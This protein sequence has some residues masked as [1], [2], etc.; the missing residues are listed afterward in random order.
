MTNLMPGD[1]AVNIS[2]KDIVNNVQYDL[3][4]AQGKV[5]ILAFVKCYCPNCSAEL[6]IL[7]DIWKK[8]Q[9]SGIQIVA[10]INRGCVAW[11][12]P[13]ETYDPA[14]DPIPPKCIQ[15]S[16]EADEKAWLQGTGP[17]DVGGVTFPVIRDPS[18]TNLYKYVT[19]FQVYP[20]L[21][22]IDR[23]YVISYFHTYTPGSVAVEAQDVTEGHILDAANIRTPV[24]IDMVMDISGTM[25][26]VPSGGMTKLALMQQATQMIID[27]L[28]GGNNAQADDR[29]GL[30]WFSDDFDEYRD[31]S[32]NKIVN[33]KAQASLMKQQ[34]AGLNIIN[35]TAM[36]AGLQTAFDTLSANSASGHKRHVFLLTDGIQNIDP[37]VK[38][39]NTHLQIVDGGSWCG[40]HSSV[41]AHPG[42][43]ISSYDTR[44][45]TIG[46]G[47]AGNYGNLLQ[48]IADETGGFYLATNDPAHDMDLL[49]FIHLCNSLA[50][51]SPAIVHH[52]T[53]TFYPKKCEVVEEFFINHSVRKITAVLSWDAVQAGNGSLVF[54]LRAP[55]GTILDLHREM[56]LYESYAI[57]TVYVPKKQN[58]KTISHV[59]NWQMI[60]HGESACPSAYHVLILADDPNTH[61]VVEFPKKSYEVGDIV[62]L[63]IR[64]KVAEQYLV[65]PV[66]LLLETSTLRVPVAELLARY[67]VP[68]RELKVI[69]G[70]SSMKSTPD[71]LALKLKA[72]SRDPEYRE[73]LLPVR[74]TVSLK[75]GNLEC[76]ISDNEIILPVTL[77]EP[78]LKTYRIAVHFE[79]EENGPIS[80]LT[81]VSL[82][83]GPGNVDPKRT[84]VNMVYVSK[85]KVK[86][87]LLHVTPRNAAGQLLG[88]GRSD[89]FG[90]L[91]G[92]K[93]TK[94]KIEDVLDG[95]YNVELVVGRK[96]DTKG[97][98]VHLMFK[99]KKFWS[100]LIKP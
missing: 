11:D 89:E 12:K 94:C 46:I 63:R 17:D 93:K 50:G 60:I 80:R 66:E 8:S 58:G 84:R 34:I 9:Q 97:Q 43:N 85:A 31:S 59:G 52:N 65:R 91:L 13:W 37:M 56:Q 30:V 45:H 81:M 83:V 92:Q 14:T 87:V 100:G 57:A 70:I 51:G 76:R 26:E 64:F 39:V 77:S 54:W 3:S 10:N 20:V 19:N 18:N 99:G 38:D 42:T 73:Y 96:I 78:G 62:P 40:P 29:M 16:E 41:P 5:I 53:G 55:D 25:G 28:S 49:Y 74:K 82:H 7:E 6:R 48:R 88:P 32:N 2:G 69:T 47:I 86:G 36:G 79:T 72:L 75:E 23:N 61:L 1:S 21:Y 95:S 98:P 4:S 33:I 71:P 35:C 27:T 24:D 22:I 44:V 15:W 90:V 68:S 67:T